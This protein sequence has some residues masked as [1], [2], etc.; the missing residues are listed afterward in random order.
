M[1]RMTRRHTYQAWAEL[2]DIV[3]EQI[4]AL[5]GL[6]CPP[7]FADEPDPAAADGLDLPP[8]ERDGEGSSGPDDGRCE[9]DGEGTFAPDG[10]GDG[11]GGSAPREG[12]EAENDATDEAH[13]FD[14][15]RLLGTARDP[16]RLIERLVADLPPPPA[17]RGAPLGATQGGGGHAG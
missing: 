9:P 5:A 11:E 2:D 17:G 14:L 1:N 12:P 7:D 10:E 15:C 13:Y 4:A 6:A 8:R 16:R 3:A